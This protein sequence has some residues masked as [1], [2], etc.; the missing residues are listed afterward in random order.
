M[1]YLFGQD[2]FYKSKET[3]REAKDDFLNVKDVFPNIK[4]AFRAKVRLLTLKFN[5]FTVPLKEPE[6]LKESEKAEFCRLFIMYW[7]SNLEKLF[8]ANGLG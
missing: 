1:G 5:H 2:A 4:R 8:H 6:K 3:F 7:F